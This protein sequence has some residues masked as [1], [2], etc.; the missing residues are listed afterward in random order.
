MGLF[1][2][3]AERLPKDVRFGQRQR[4][5]TPLRLGL[6]LT[7][8]CASQHVEPIADFH[9]AFPAFWGTT[10]TYKAFYNHVAKPHCAD[11]ARTRA[12]R[13]ISAMTLPVLG[14]ETGRAVGEFR[15]IILQDGSSLALHDSVREGFPRALQS[16]QA[17]RR[18]TPHHAGPRV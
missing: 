17:R 18:R 5:I 8:T 7:T 1:R 14:C 3:V 6:A 9:R 10:S 12:A 11:C 15:H 2:V 4:I 13:L 16:R